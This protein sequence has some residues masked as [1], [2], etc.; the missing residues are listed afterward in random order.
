MALHNGYSCFCVEPGRDE[1]R[2]CAVCDSIMDVRR[3]VNGPIGSIQAQFGVKTLHDEF[4]CPLAN[5][6]WHEHAQ[7]LKYEMNDTASVS[8]QRV[9]M[10]ELDL[11]V[12]LRKVPAL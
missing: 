5:E 1:K 6:D 9:L 11:T 2:T 7:K 3:N 8:I 10:A 4:T 12:Q